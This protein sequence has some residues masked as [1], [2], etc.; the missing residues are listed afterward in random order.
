MGT[1]T[2][3]VRWLALLLV[4]GLV[5]SA[6]G[7]DDD[8]TAQDEGGTDTSEEEGAAGE[9]VHGGRLVYGISA[10]TANTWPGTGPRAPHPATR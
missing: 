10:D 8:D 2:R 5:A 7:G 6:C 1:R 9:P 3:P 4:L